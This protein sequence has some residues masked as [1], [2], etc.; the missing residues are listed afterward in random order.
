MGV[1]VGGVG[2]G[3]KPA[4]THSGWYSTRPDDQRELVGKS[5]SHHKPGAKEIMYKCHIQSHKNKFKKMSAR[6]RIR[7]K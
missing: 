5:K 6:P 7:V 4:E 1:G 2:E 3:V